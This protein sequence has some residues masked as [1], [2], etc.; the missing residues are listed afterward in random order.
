MESADRV[1]LSHS[2]F[3]RRD[4]AVP[5]AWNARGP[6]L[7]GISG[8]LPDLCIAMLDTGNRIPFC[9][10]C[11]T[12]L[13]QTLPE[14]LCT[15]CGRPIVSTAV[16]EGVHPCRSATSAV[17]RRMILTWR[18]ALGRIRQQCLVQS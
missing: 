6:R 4:G 12:G 3:P 7:A 13:T 16:A 5:V 9:R 2:G 14:P 11:V 1:G 15:Q 10:A 18:A 17:F 8:P